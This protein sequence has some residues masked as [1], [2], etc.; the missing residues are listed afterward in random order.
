MEVYLKSFSFA[1]SSNRM[2]KLF[3]AIIGLNLQYFRNN[4]E[5]FSLCLSSPTKSNSSRYFSS[6]LE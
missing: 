5:E 1:F 6:N 3:S 4:L 2:K